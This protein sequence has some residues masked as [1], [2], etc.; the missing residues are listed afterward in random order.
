MPPMKDLKK[1]ILKYH[2][3][4]AKGGEAGADAKDLFEPFALDCARK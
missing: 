3:T 1:R 2:Y 4:E